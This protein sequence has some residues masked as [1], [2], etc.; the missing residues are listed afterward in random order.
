VSSHDRHE[1]AGERAGLLVEEPFLELAVQ[2]P[3]RGALTEVGLEDRRQRQP[4]TLA[5]GL[6]RVG[7]RT[8]VRS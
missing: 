4:T 5:T 1:L 7:A 6:V 8:P 2:R 3:E